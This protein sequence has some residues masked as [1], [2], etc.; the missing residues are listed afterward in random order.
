MRATVQPHN[1]RT[2]MP[3]S[4]DSS[5]SSIL[6]DYF[7]IDITLSLRYNA[8]IASK[9]RRCA[10]GRTDSDLVKQLSGYSLTT[11]EILYRRPD[12][13]AILQSYIWQ[14]FDLYPRFPRLRGFLDFWEA[15]LEGPLHS[16]RVAHCRLIKPAEVRLL[17]G[18]FRLN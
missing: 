8:N 4:Q 2:H 12:Y 16:V 11:A 1:S 5:D 3:M 7:F 10:M 6:P 15:N 9:D 18:D 17:S 14:E 13:P